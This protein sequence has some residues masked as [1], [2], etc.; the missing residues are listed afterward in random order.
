MHVDED[1]KYHIMHG[2]LGQSMGEMRTYEMLL[3]H[4]VF[5]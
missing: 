2:M 3:A 5:C 4:K 1:E